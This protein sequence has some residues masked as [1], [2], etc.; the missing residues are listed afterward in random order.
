MALSAKNKFQNEQEL[1]KYLVAE[2]YF[3][4]DPSI[5][6]DSEA[7]IQ[8]CRDNKNQRTKLDS[9]ME[10]YGLSNSEGI[11]LMCLAESLIRIPDDQTRDSLI[12]EKLTSGHTIYALSVKKSAAMLGQPEVFEINFNSQCFSCKT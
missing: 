3:L 1:A 7:L 10:E 6:N 9:F 4:D 8:F 5:A 11:A 2:S 12:N